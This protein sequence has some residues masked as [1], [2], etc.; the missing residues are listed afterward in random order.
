MCKIQL[1]LH[2]CQYFRVLLAPRG[3]SE[4]NESLLFHK[5]SLLPQT[6][7]GN[8]D[9]RQPDSIS[10]LDTLMCINLASTKFSKFSVFSF[11]AKFST[12]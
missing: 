4:K 6:E 2:Q 3:V 12:H 10:T 9:T 5:E 8:P 11:F 1:P 7:L